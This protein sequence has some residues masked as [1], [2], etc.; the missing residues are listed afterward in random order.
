M[1]NAMLEGQQK[2]LNGMSK[3][4]VQNCSGVFSESAADNRTIDGINDEK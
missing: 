1:F 4:G 3:N 2:W